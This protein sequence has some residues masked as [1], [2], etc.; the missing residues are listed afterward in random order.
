MRVAV[1]TPSQ[2]KTISVIMPTCTSPVVP[3]LCMQHVPRSAAAE[4]LP[5]LAAPPQSAAATQPAHTPLHVERSTITQKTHTCIWHSPPE[6]PHNLLEARPLLRH[7]RPAALHQRK[8]SLQPT[9]TKRR[10]VRP[11]QGIDWR[12]VQAAAGQHMGYQVPGVGGAKGQLPG[13]QLPQHDAKR[14]DVW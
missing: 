4:G 2:T 3:G 6:L 9:A 7:L 10:G 1:S 8:V 11:R 14:V 12:H 5:T 13:Q